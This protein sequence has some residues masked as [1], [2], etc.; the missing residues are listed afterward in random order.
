MR[1]LRFLDD[2][3]DWIELKTIIRISSER[4]IKSTKLTQKEVRYYISSST[5]DAIYFN[6]T[7]RQHWSIENNLHWSLD[8]FFDEDRNL[9][10]KENSAQN[11]NVVNKMALALLE[12]E[13]ST[14]AS[15][16]SKRTKAA[17]SDKYR[18]KLIWG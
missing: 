4:Y 2:K 16:P 8:V 12:R 3:E 17:L 5:R 6:K 14:K 7:V 18:E 15:K 9:K 13:N 1:D 10:K 11:F